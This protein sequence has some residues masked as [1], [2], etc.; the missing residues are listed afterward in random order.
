MLNRIVISASILFIAYNSLYSQCTYTNTTFQSGEEVIYKVYYKLGFMWFNAAQASFS[1][2]TTNYNNKKVLHFDS[3]GQTLPNYDWIYKV[4]DHFQSYSDSV[5][6]RPLYFSRV[7]SEGNFKVNNQYVF[8]YPKSKI[9]SSVENSEK[10]KKRDTLN[11]Q[12]CTYDVLTA[13]YAC[14]NT[15]V[16]KL[17]RNDTIP[18]KMIVD[19]KTYELYLRYLG[20]ENMQLNDERVF[21]C[22]KFTILMIEGTI[23]AGGENIT[24]W[25]S[26]DNAK[27]PIRVE[28]EILVGS[29]VAE[30]D[31]LR[32]NK[33]PIQSQIATIKK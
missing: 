1:I 16:A 17:K 27:I 31:A 28:A 30:V 4:R 5:D 24:V 15:D 6:L 3:Y 33:W 14:R 29:I 18:L 12:S 11:I 10:P 13:I 2:K 23:F 32:G 9:Y 19:N 7:T 20:I 22:R 25:I 8:D 21:R 26:D